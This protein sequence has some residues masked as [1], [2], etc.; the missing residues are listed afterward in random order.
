MTNILK[1]RL[2]SPQNLVTD[3]L[4][5]NFK[6]TKRL[7]LGIRIS[8]TWDDFI[9]GSAPLASVLYSNEEGNLWILFTFYLSIFMIMIMHKKITHIVN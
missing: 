6:S 5:I 1:E 2:T 3:S 7:L 8:F 9:I 4:S